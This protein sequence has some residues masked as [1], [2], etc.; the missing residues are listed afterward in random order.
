MAEL[1]LAYEAR[2]YSTGIVGRSICNARNQHWVAENSGGEAVGAG[3][4]FCASVAACAVNMVETVASNEQ[5]A[6]DRMD[7]N[8]AA[9]RDSDKLAGEVSLYDAVRIQFQL[10]GVSEDD[11]RF[12]VKTW[13][14]R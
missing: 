11:A 8:V 3:E 10:W 1:A 4:L 2:S 14:Q 7:V 9:Y 6:L 13:K 12:L 5:R